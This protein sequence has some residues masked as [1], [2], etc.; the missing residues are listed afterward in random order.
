MITLYK[1]TGLFSQ[2]KNT[3]NPHR[4]Q[5]DKEQQTEQNVSDCLFVIGGLRPGWW[6]VQRLL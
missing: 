1:L 6:Q 4:E 3:F 5:A 2:S